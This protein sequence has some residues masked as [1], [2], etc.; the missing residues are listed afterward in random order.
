M[1]LKGS[2][3]LKLACG[4]RGIKS[5]NGPQKLLTKVPCWRPSHH[6]CRA[7]PGQ[8]CLQHLKGHCFRWAADTEAV[9]C[10]QT[11]D[12]K[13]IILGPNTYIVLITSAPILWILVTLT[14]FIR[15]SIYKGSLSSLR[16]RGH[17]A[18]SWPGNVTLTPWACLQTFHPTE[19]TRP[20][21]QAPLWP[22]P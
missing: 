8:V 19:S 11:I 1:C 20:R 6:L 15:K 16:S 2:E 17:T 22:D 13:N 21:V 10:L 12:M 9:L 5:Q 4:A 14:D 18:P 3:A 7:Q